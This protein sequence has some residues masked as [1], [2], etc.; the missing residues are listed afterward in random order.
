MLNSIT[1]TLSCLFQSTTVNLLCTICST[2]TAIH[3]CGR[4][5]GL[6]QTCTA[7]LMGLKA[8][9]LGPFLIPDILT[10]RAEV[11]CHGPWF[12]QHARLCKQK[13]VAAKWGVMAPSMPCASQLHLMFPLELLG[14]DL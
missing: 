4:H 9:L 11:P 10:R 3:R 13:V 6:Q 12:L 1:Q 14:A 5:V 8:V 7:H 2:G